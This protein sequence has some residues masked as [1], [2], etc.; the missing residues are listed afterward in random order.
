MSDPVLKQAMAEIRA[1]MNHHDIGGA[2]TLVSPTHSEFYYHLTPSWSACYFPT[3]NELRF[4]AKK[5]DFKTEAEQ[6]RCVT[7]TVHMVCQ[8]RDIAAQNFT[9]MEQVIDRLG[10]H[11]KI[12]HTPYAD[13]EPHKEH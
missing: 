8:I 1:I 4:R 6:E 7:L 5:E 9:Q 3:S 10:E 12:E 11:Y 13:F 2:V